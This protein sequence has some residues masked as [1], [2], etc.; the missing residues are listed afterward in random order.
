MMTRLHQFLEGERDFEDAI[1]TEE[2]V[3]PVIVIPG[4]SI[5]DDKGRCFGK[6]L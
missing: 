5:I 3:V 2:Y 1:T 6:G 4:G